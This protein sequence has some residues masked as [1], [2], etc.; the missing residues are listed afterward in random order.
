M[1]HKLDQIDRAILR[2]LQ[3]DTTLSVDDISVAVNLSRNAC[4]RRIKTLEQS[5]TIKGRVALVDPGHVG[6]P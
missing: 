5:G 6:V 1:T 2:I 3:T 4:W